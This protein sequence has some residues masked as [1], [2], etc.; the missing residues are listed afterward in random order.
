MGV[1]S[2]IALGGAAT[3]GIAGAL[4]SKSQTSA[5]KQARDLERGYT[6]ESLSEI[7]PWR[8][9]GTRG[10]AEFEKMIFEGPGEMTEDPGYQFELSEGLK[11]FRRGASAKGTL[12]SGAHAK[13][14]VR[15]GQGLASK[16]YDQFLNRYRARLGD[17]GQLVGMGQRAT[18]FGAGL[19]ERTGQRAGAHQ[20]DIGAARASGYAN[21]SNTISG[22]LRDITTLR[23]L[24][25]K[26]NPYGQY[27]PL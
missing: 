4:G 14:L 5:A 18:E 16:R 12:G 24:K 2:A 21:I 27:G 10:L 17:F 1:T 19:R 23:N 8:E 26:R 6:E 22:G 15:Y 20:Q 11:A 9:A 25:P 13:E 3:K 7:A